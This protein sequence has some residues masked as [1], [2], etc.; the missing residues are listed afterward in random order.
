MCVYEDGVLKLLLLLLVLVLLL[1]LVLPFLWDLI[2][3]DCKDSRPCP[4]SGLMLT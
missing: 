2:Y 1:L 4:R 3:A